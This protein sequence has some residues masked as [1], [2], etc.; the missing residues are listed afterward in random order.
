MNE[1]KQLHN[2]LI[3][4][5]LHNITSF[6]IIFIIFGLFMFVMIKNI[7]YSL[8]NKELKE[9]KLE[10]LKVERQ[11]S[12]NK[13]LYSKY[14]TPLKEFLLQNEDYYMA[15]VIS[16]PKIAVIIR[17]EKGDLINTSKLGN[18]KEYIDEVK[19]DEKNIDK[20]YEIVVNQKY[21]YRGTNFRITSLDG[22]I[23]NIELLINIDSEKN[24]I[25]NYFDITMSAV[26]IGIILSIVA[27]YILSRKN[28]VPI[29]EIIHKQM[30]FVQNASHE[31]RTPLTII[32]AKQELMLQE[33]EAKIIDKSEEIM[34]T[35]NETKRLTKLTKDLMI[36]SRADAKNM[37]IQKENINIDEYIESIVKPY[38]EIADMQNKK[39]I[40]KL[41][42]KGEISVD[43]GKIYQLIIILLDNALKYTEE[44]DTIEVV[45]YLKDN[46][47]NIEIRDTGI[48]VTDEGLKR[49]FE[50]F[51]RE[52]K[53]RSRET[54]GSGLGLSIASM[55]VK[56]HGG[57]I[58]AMH[59]KPKG[60][61]FLIRLTK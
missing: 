33:P 45:T 39:I 34:I 26:V 38:I 15:N 49:I 25:S 8:V 52:D 14:Y 18:L 9:S 46:K 30:E 21:S 36:L 37:E 11:Y 53:A 16:N 56:A 24:L 4:L 5:M 59:N 43:T 10:I 13:E 12:G 47:C 48:G 32:Q 2:N 42:Y 35:L 40:C 44:N 1:E 51:Y 61:V 31:L 3:K 55:I 58:K 22:T 57:S 23:R 41:D 60:T 7:T 50:R 19:F 27:S 20:I 17:D 28:I 6:A 29:Q 54:G